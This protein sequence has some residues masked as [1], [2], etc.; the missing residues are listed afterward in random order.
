MNDPLPANVR[1]FIADQIESV[2]QLE[3][4]LLL[5]TDPQQSWNAQE[6]ASRLYISEKMC[7]SML[8]DLERRKF[9]VRDPLKK[10]VR[11]ECLNF[12]ADATVAVLTELYRDRRVAVISEIHSTPISKVQTFAD[13]FRLRKD[14]KL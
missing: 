10:S 11:Y 5:R 13:A 1:R 8:E 3:T 6:L 7:R 9:I 12:E 2:A 4:L 14:D